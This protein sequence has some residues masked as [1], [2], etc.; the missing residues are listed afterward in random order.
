VTAEVA[1]TTAAEAVALGVMGLERAFGGAFDTATAPELHA[2]ARLLAAKGVF[3][4][5]TLVH[6]ER[7]SQ[8]L[9]P[10]IRQDPLLQHLPPGWFSWWDAPYGVGTWTEVHSTRQR[11]I[12]S[13]KQTLLNAFAKANGRVVAGSATPNPYIF[14]GAGLRRELELLVQAGLTPLQAIRAATQVA[15]EFL[16]QGARLGTLEPGKLADMVIL[17]G[18]PLADISQIRQVEVVL[19]DGQVVWKK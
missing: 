8:L 11:R 12:L 14:P 4:L 17:G 7:L 6:N 3:V 10:A 5:P 15:A 16:G 19:R 18:N 1:A 2:L 9:D 13:Q